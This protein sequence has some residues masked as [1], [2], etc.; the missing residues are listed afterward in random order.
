M[1]KGPGATREK[2]WVVDDANTIRSL[3]RYFLPYPATG[4]PTIEGNLVVGQTLTADVSGIVDRNGL[5]DAFDYQW[6]RSDGENDTRI[7]GATENTYVLTE[8]DLGGRVRV[9]VSFTDGHS[10]EETLF[11]DRTRPL[12]AP[13]TGS[14]LVVKTSRVL[15]ATLTADRISSGVRVRC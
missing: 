5:P 12:N 8:S 3:F 7:D 11:S 1:R 10:Y 9:E 6:Y 2:L 14:P 13:A 15:S 4:R